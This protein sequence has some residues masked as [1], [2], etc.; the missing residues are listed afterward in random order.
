VQKASFEDSPMSTES[1]QM[2][3]TLP[4]DHYLR[5][6]HFSAECKAIFHSEWFCVGR[7]DDLKTRGDFRLV[8][9]AGESILLVCDENTE[10]RAFYNVCRHR[11]SQLVMA[12]GAS[13]QA[14]CFGAGIR[15]PYH[16]WNYRL[17]GELHSTPHLNIDKSD[18]GLHR[19]DIDT[20]GGFVFVRLTPGEQSLADMLGEI[21]DRVSR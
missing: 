10:L 20:W 12:E 18:L 17:N 7:C 2:E 8:N 14:G 1:S 3:A 11:G 19:V 21:A 13:E 16:S 15:C 4:G 5:D 6:E 9:V